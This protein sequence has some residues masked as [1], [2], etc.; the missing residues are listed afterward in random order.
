MNIDL[1]ALS[2]FCVLFCLPVKSWNSGSWASEICGGGIGGVFSLLVSKR[3]LSDLI[4][5]RHV[6]S[7]SHD[8]FRHEVWNNFDQQNISI[9]CRE[10]K[11]YSEMDI[12]FAGI[13]FKKKKGEMLGDERFFS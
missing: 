1:F 9:I 8:M 13:L 7:F 12:D 3:I 5:S 11:I 6:I 2:E 10:E 4:I